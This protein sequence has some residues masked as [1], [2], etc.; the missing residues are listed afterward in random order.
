MITTQEKSSVGNMFSLNVIFQDVTPVF[1][2]A[3]AEVSKE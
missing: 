2:E 3:R 1:W